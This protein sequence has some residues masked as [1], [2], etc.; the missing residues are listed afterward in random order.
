MNNENNGYQIEFDRLPAK[1][2]TH[3]HESEFWESLGRAIAAFGFLEE[4]LGKAIFALTATRSYSESEILKAYEKW[5]PKLE[6]ALTDQLWNLTV[7]FGKEIADHPDTTLQNPEV[8]IK[9]L[10]EASKIRNVICHGS[11]LPPDSSGASIPL[12]TNRQL[13]RFE[14]PIDTKFLDQT[15]IHTTELI[16]EVVNT[17]TRM[18]FQF[19]GTEGPGKV[20][21][22][23]KK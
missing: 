23:I 17:V 21:W 8:L 11:W 15:Q 13:E 9:Y 10:K 20:I 3:K 5:K 14:S 1:L 2:P 7:N 19:P 18:D 4:T 12:F 22:G 6:K 16:C